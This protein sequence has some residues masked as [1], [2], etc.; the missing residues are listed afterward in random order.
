MSTTHK[1]EDSMVERA[2]LFISENLICVMHS[3]I[4]SYGVAEISSNV[5]HIEKVL[6]C[7]ENFTSQ[8]LI[9]RTGRY[10]K[11]KTIDSNRQ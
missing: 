8:S 5:H 2:L 4:S 6:E 1:P 10:I 7:A 9:F 3:Q 11:H